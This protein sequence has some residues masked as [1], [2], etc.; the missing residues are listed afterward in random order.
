VRRATKIAVVGGAVSA[1]VVG[2]TFAC[3]APGRQGAGG[4]ATALTRSGTAKPVDTSLPSPQVILTT[5]KVF[6]SAGQAGNR[7]NAA[8]LTGNQGRFARHVVD[9]G[10]QSAVR[11]RGRVLRTSATRL[12]RAETASDL[13]GTAAQTIGGLNG[14]VGR[15]TGTAEVD[16]RQKCHSWFGAYRDDVTTAGASDSREGYKFAGRSVTAV[17][18]TS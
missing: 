1:A 3:Y 14:D 10:Q 2:V 15:K 17:I 4:H 8:A 9:A 16:G 12:S 13:Q 11:L 5:A 6:R 7:A 18:L